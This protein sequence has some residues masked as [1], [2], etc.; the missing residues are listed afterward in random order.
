MSADYQQVATANT[1]AI[2]GSVPD[3]KPANTFVDQNG[4][5]TAFNRRSLIH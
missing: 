1:V 3:T 2:D 4:R 5:V